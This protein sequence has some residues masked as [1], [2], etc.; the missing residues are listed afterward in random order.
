MSLEVV[1][2]VMCMS[3]LEADPPTD[4]PPIGAPPPEP[5]EEVELESAASISA[6]NTESVAIRTLSGGTV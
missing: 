4:P 3:E 5:E 6:R 2:V 1:E